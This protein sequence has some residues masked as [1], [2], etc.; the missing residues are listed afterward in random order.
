[1]HRVMR[2]WPWRRTAAPVPPDGA[3]S[4]ITFH[5]RQSHTAKSTS[6]NPQPPATTAPA[7]NGRRTL[8]E[9]MKERGFTNPTPNFSA[10]FADATPAADIS[11]ADITTT[12][13]VSIC[14]KKHLYGP[15][16][17]MS[18]TLQ[19]ELFIDH[20]AFIFYRPANGL[21]YGI[22]KLTLM[23][24]GE[25][26]TVFTMKLETYVYSHTAA[27]APQTGTSTEVTGM[28]NRISNATSNYET[29]TLSGIFRSVP[30]GQKQ[31]D[32]TPGQFN[33]AKLSPWDPSTAEAPYS[34]NQALMEVF[35]EIF[36]E[37]LQL[38]S[39]LRREKGAE[40]SA[41]MKASA[42]IGTKHLDLE[43]YKVGSIPGIYYIPDY[44]SEREEAQ[45]LG[46]LSKTPVEFKSK[47]TKRTVQEWGCTMCGECN[48]SFVADVNMPPW[49]Q[50]CTDMLVYDGIFTP[51]TFPNSVRIHEYEKGE[52]IGPHC[53]GPIYV[54][55]VTVLSLASTSVMNFYPRQEPYLD[56]PMDHYNDTFKFSEGQI[57]SQ[58]PVQT[59]VMEPR[60]L[61][62]FMG[63][64]Y[65]HYPHGVSDKEVDDLSPEVSGEVVN[66]QF[67]RDKDIMKVHREYRVSLTTRNL[68]TRCNHQPSRA[69]YAMKRAWHLYHHLPVPEPLFADAPATA[70]AK[71][72]ADSDEEEDD[73]DDYDGFAG[74]PMA[75]LLSSAGVKF[76][77]ETPE[78][79]SSEQIKAWGEK[80]D[81]IFK[82]QEELKASVE[83]LQQLLVSSITAEASF[84]QEVSTVLNHLSTTMLDLDEKVESLEEA[85]S[86]QP[87]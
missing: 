48:Q 9:E 20:D 42:P 44:I 14:V 57:G 7:G 58:T 45:M 17:V 41:K 49:V 67:L 50:Q 16:L 63:D 47:L 56:K 54:P 10:D 32:Q 31:V 40:T 80:L 39:H 71:N 75:R 81:R 72:D 33:A 55:V 46:M 21:G 74:S 76:E 11:A 69:E 83:G 60:S 66:R 15:W 51:A 70:S 64:A 53:D 61:L 65:Y 52:G 43:Q 28:V 18:D 77:P 78:P 25:A 5:S 62:V 4:A 1:M 35:K 85:V 3:L 29:L 79:L 23:N 59:V 12:P 36:P 24:A 26:G 2:G 34:G 86:S 30:T 37:E 6:Q 84:R 87:K 82:Q 19:G 73:N 8:S 13:A 22:G 68:L 27:F 38:D